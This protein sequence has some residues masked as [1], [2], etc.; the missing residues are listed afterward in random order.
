MERTP[1][2]CGSSYLDFQPTGPTGV[3]TGRSDRKSQERL[4]PV[5]FFSQEIV[6]LV[7]QE[8]ERLRTPRLGSR[9]TSLCYRDNKVAWK[10]GE[11]CA[12]CCWTP[13]AASLWTEAVQYSLYNAGMLEGGKLS[14]STNGDAFEKINILIDQQ[15]IGFMPCQLSSGGYYSKSA[16]RCAER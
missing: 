10:W 7:L 6:L 5:V 13:G 4:Y 11:T 16:D 15:I 2:L 9:N 3:L 14:I 8:R 12:G 1:V